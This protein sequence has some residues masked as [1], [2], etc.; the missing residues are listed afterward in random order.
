V[1]LPL[2]IDPEEASLIEVLER[3]LDGCI[4]FEPSARL[5]LSSANLKTDNTSVVAFPDRR[6]KPFFIPETR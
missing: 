3:I 1:S 6:S 5:F 2:R 4:R